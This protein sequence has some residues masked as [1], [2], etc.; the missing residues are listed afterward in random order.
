MFGIRLQ[1]V[2][3]ARGESST[4]RGNWVGVVQGCGEHIMR[5]HGCMRTS[6]RAKPRLRFLSQDVK[7]TAS[8]CRMASSARCVWS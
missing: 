3:G 7:P 4:A 2:A 8:A 1:F 5:A 6:S